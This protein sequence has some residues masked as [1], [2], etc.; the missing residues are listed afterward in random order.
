MSATKRRPVYIVR[1]AAGRECGH[2]HATVHT[3]A[4]CLLAE[5]DGLRRQGRRY[6]WRGLVRV[7]VAGNEHTCMGGNA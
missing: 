2:H 6:E 3:G 7:D 4:N 5:L 1:T